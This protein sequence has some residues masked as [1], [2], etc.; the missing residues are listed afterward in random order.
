LNPW[1]VQI[2]DTNRAN[3]IQVDEMRAVLDDK[4]A[5]MY[6]KIF[7]T[8][9]PIKKH[10]LAMEFNRINNPEFQ[11]ERLYSLGMFDKFNRTPLYTP[12]INNISMI[13]PSIPVLYEW[14][15][16]PSV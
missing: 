1:N 5:Q 14:D 3:Y 9:R 16:V 6:E 13:M 15:K 8:T 2:N 11:D 7:D 12:Q 10:Y 4:A